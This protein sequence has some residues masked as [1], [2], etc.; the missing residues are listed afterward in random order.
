M[1]DLDVV[2]ERSL[3]AVFLLALE[4][5][6]QPTPYHVIAHQFLEFPSVLLL[7]PHLL[8][9]PGCLLDLDHLQRLDPVLQVCHSPVEFRDELEVVDAGEVGLGEL[10]RIDLSF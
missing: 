9:A 3:R 6:N 2:L 10:E 8:R 1:L 4:A 5:L 7:L